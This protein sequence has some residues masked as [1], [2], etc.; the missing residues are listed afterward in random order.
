VVVSL[1]RGA[2]RSGRSDSLL[3]GGFPPGGAFPSWR[4]SSPCGRCVPIPGGK[5]LSGEVSFPS[6]RGVP[7]RE[8]RSRCGRVRC[9]RDDEFLS[10]P[11]SLS[12]GGEFLAARCSS[13]REV[14]FP[15]GGT[16]PVRV[17]AGSPLGGAL[18]SG[19]YVLLGGA[20]AA[21]RRGRSLGVRRRLLLVA[22]GTGDRA[23]GIPLAR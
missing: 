17:G 15:R 4:W 22:L 3:G 18:P 14:S 12:P 8:V 19:N 20:F 10:G 16:V 21:R 13:L 9:L 6:G 5:L 7:L 11:V 1:P 23:P 2:F